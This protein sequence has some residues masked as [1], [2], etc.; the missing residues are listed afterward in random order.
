MKFRINPNDAIQGMFTYIVTEGMFS[1]ALAGQYIWVFLRYLVIGL[2]FGLSVFLVEWAIFTKKKASFGRR[3][4]NRV[5]H[6]LRISIV[7]L[8]MIWI[9][10]VH[11]WAWRDVA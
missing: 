11:R 1:D 6:F 10:E 7:W 3:M 4:L 8:P 5:S 2:C 9:E